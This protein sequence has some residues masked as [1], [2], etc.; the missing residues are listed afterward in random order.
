[1]PL[2]SDINIT[3]GYSCKIVLLWETKNPEPHIILVDIHVRIIGTKKKTFDMTCQIVTIRDTMRYL[4]NIKAQSV[5]LHM[6]TCFYLRSFGRV[7]GVG[8][9]FFVMRAA[10]EHQIQGW[11]RNETDGSVSICAQGEKRDIQA[12]IETVRARSDPHIRVDTLKIHE[13]PVKSFEGF[14][15]RHAS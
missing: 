9:R 1:M 12:F 2:Q 7:Q 5:Y 15:I 13:S 4:T 10:N 3:S 11:V 8:Y 14:T 6:K